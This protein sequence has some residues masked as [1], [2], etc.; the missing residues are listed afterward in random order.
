MVSLLVQK[1]GVTQI[2]LASYLSTE[3]SMLNRYENAQRNISAQAVIDMVE[4][5]KISNSFKVSPQL[6]PS[7]EETATLKKEATWL[8]AKCKPLQKKLD[9]MQMRYQQAGNMLQLLD[10]L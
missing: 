2:A 8:K 6:N 10:A 1:T 4:L 9:A 3:P 7:T 5:L